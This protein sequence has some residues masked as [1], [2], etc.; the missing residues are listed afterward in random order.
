MFGYLDDTQGG[1]KIQ[2]S[3]TGKLNI[4]IAL[5]ISPSMDIQSIS[6]ATD[7][8]LTLVEKVRNV[9][10]CKKNILVL[11]RDSRNSI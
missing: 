1:R 4:Y 5:D 7:L 6:V 2:I 3:E 10:L 8:I 11:F 9:F